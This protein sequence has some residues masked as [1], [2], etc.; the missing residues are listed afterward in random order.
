[1]QRIGVCAA[2]AIANVLLCAAPANAQSQ[3][4][5]FVG[6]N[7]NDSNNC[8][9]TSPCRSFAAA[10]LLT[11]PGGEIA[12]LDPVGYGAVTITKAISIINDGGGEVGINDP[13]AGQNAITINAGPSDVVTLKGLTLNGVNS[14][15]DGIKFTSGGTLNVQNCAIRGFTDAGIKF[16]PTASSTL[17]I[18]DTI[19]SNNSGS[20]GGIVLD[21]SGT[22]L[23]V[24]AYLGEDQVFG[25]G[26]NGIYVTGANMSG[27][28]LRVRIADSDIN[29]QKSGAGVQI[30]ASS[31]TATVSIVSTALTNNQF[32]FRAVSGTSYISGSTISGSTNGFSVS[33][34]GVLNSFQNSLGTNYITDTPNVGSLSPI[35]Q[36]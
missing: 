9:R 17:T 19:V 7:G 31:S 30:P 14:G 20:L 32:G 1:M 36:Q 3:N 8:G 21:P 18:L 2:I 12:T 22:G 16:L 29:G 27:G 10:I 23:T 15:N 28:S 11:N 25:N 33:G 26:A 13:G 4:R 24:N 34:S 35:V 6:L 5:T